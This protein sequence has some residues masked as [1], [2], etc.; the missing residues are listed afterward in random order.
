MLPG[1]SGQ[2][3]RTWGF[4]GFCERS[5]RVHSG[6]CVCKYLYVHARLS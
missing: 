6:A 3:L 4:C 1:A 5:E 2:Q